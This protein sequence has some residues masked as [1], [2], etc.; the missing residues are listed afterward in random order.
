LDGQAGFCCGN[1]HEMSVVVKPASGTVVVGDGYEQAPAANVGVPTKMYP[2]VD[3][4]HVPGPVTMPRL[5]LVPV[6]PASVHTKA[7][8]VQDAVNVGAP[9]LH[10]AGGEVRA[11]N[12][13][14]SLELYSEGHVLGA[15]AEG[16]S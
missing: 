10:C 4:A 14:T 1:P 9:Q 13:V 3:P 12:A 16:P 7:V 5:A 11:W 15:D 6:H 2:G 8:A